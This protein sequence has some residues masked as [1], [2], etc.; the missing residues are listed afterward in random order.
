MVMDVVVVVDKITVLEE[1]KGGPSGAML[2]SIV[3]SILHV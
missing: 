2:K 3:L 1:R